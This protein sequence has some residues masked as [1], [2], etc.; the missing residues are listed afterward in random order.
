M[1]NCIRQTA[2]FTSAVEQSQKSLG[3]LKQL[4]IPVYKS[5]IWNPDTHTNLVRQLCSLL[6]TFIYN[7][8]TVEVS[9]FHISF[10]LLQVSQGHVS[11]LPSLGIAPFE[12]QHALTALRATWLCPE[13]SWVCACNSWVKNLM[14]TSALSPF[15]SRGLVGPLPFW[16]FKGLHFKICLL[17]TDL[18]K[19][20]KQQRLYLPPKATS[21]G[22]CQS[23]SRFYVKLPIHAVSI[24][25]TTK[26]L[27]IFFSIQL[28][29]L[30]L[31]DSSF[32]SVSECPVLNG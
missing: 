17:K 23:L 29:F 25:Q 1:R 20:A 3:L 5:G 9:R 7:L 32:I 10:S 8:S 4:R 30:W 6:V 22:Y 13:Q 2:L 11:S 14:T 24:D 15:Q 31:S 27:F 12:I 26:C 18:W 28:E 21:I 19:K 16:F